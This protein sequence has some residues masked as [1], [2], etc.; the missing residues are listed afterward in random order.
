MKNVKELKTTIIGLIIW[1]ATGLYFV[2]PYFSEREL[3]EID[4]I[5]VISGVVAGLLLLLAPD[6]FVTFLFGWLS[7]KTN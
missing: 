4:N 1:V 5:Y 3:W 7:K 6:K 2:T